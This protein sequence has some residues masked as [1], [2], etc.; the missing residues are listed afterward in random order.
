LV[1]STRAAEIVDKVLKNRLVGDRSR[2]ATK[3]LKLRP[4]EVIF[5]PE[6]FV[7]FFTLAALEAGIDVKA[8]GARL[9]PKASSPE[10]IPGSASRTVAQVA[11]VYAENPGAPPSIPASI[12]R[13]RPGLPADL[14]G[15]VSSCPLWLLPARPAAR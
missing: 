10:Y 6:H 12:C 9:N 2:A 4:D 1:H 11:G 14:R 8:Y 15:A 3:L 13:R 5:W 7:V